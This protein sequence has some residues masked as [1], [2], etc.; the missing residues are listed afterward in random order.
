MTTLLKT[1]N[2][3]RKGPQVLDIYIFDFPVLLFIFKK[4]IDLFHRSTVY[5]MNGLFNIPDSTN[6]ISFV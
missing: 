5:D 6:V 2:I 4:F 3:D 1:Q